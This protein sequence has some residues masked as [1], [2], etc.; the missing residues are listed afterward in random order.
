MLLGDK[1]Y[2][3]DWLRDMIWEQGGW[4][5][6]ASRAGRKEPAWFSPSLCKKRNLVERFLNKPKSV[7]RI[8]TRYD[9]LG[10]NFL[11]IV[12]LAALPLRL[13]AYEATASANPKPM[14]SCGVGGGR[15]G[16]RAAPRAALSSVA[17]ANDFRPLESC[18]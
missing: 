17:S 3:A 12:K 15:A 5:N 9:E 14:I 6:I 18:M 2:D 8:A 4:V 7:R 13:R 11:A 10:R 16:Q 1:A